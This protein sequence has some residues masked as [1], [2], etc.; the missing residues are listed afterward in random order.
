MVSHRRRT[1]INNPY[2]AHLDPKPGDVR[3]EFA[4][5]LFGTPAGL[6][7]VVGVERKIWFM[8]FRHEFMKQREEVAHVSLQEI[9]KCFA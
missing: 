5:T 2:N 1:S 7:R 6:I 8:K 4:Y 3:P 9:G